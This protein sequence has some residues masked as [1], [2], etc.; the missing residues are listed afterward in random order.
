MAIQQLER[1]LRQKAEAR[2]ARLQALL[3]EHGIVVDDAE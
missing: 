2:A 3:A 1:Q